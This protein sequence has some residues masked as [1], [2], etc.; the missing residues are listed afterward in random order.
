MR[1]RKT[2]LLKCDQCAYDVRGEVF[3][4]THRPKDGEGTD[5]ELHFCS[6]SCLDDYLEDYYLDKVTEAVRAEANRTAR[7]VCPAC[8]RRLLKHP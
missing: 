4:I 8:R 1:S 5:E 3:E 2:G 7:L 6:Q